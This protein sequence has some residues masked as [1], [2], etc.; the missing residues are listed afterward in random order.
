[1]T[2]HQDVQNRTLT[3]ARLDKYIEADRTVLEQTDNQGRTPLEAA[4]VAG[5]ADEVLLLLKSDAKADTL[6]KDGESPLLFAASKTDKNRARIIQ[7]L[8][9]KTPSSFIDA[10]SPL[11]GNNTP[12]MYVVQKKDVKSI[13]LLREARAPLTLT[14]DD[15][16][17]AKDLAEKI[18]D[19]VVGLLLFIVAWVNKAVVGL[20]L[21]IVAWVNKAVDGVVRRMY[22][23]SVD[24]KRHFSSLAEVAII[25][26]E[27]MWRATPTEANMVET[28]Y[29]LVKD[30]PIKRF[31]DDKEDFIQEVAKNTV[32]LIKDT[33]TSLGSSDLLHK[34]IKVSL[35]Q[36]VIYCGKCFRNGCSKTTATPWSFYSDKDGI[37]DS[38]SMNKRSGRE[39]LSE[40][41]NPTRWESQSKLV[42]R[43][44]E[45]TTLILPQ[46][47]GA[48]LRFINQKEPNSFSN[49]SFADIRE[50]LKPLRPH[51]GEPKG[52]SS[53]GTN[54]EDKILKPLIY[55]K[56]NSSKG[57]ERP[58]LISII[59]DGAPGP[60]S[61]DRLKKA[62]VDCGRQLN[63]AKYPRE[64]A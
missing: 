5:D 10:N 50:I 13:R 19:R 35:H 18:Y 64:S 57:L 20:F 47:E 4:T 37:D 29:D 61:K 55:E 39:D 26:I 63:D 48:A 62:I 14:N 43:I 51:P 40:M 3:E 2:I 60:E 23:L 36:Q 44:A 46:N 15:G 24:L 41:N 56:L 34:T 1:M 30:T 45:I 6:S 42:E 17:N 27:G 38:S 28:V 58:I 16:Y 49:L 54:L 25:F 7:L 21:F 11:V 59:T 9:A 33:S 31:F 52:T 12:L 53:I 22:D 8:L 32:K